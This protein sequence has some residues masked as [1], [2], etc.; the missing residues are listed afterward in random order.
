MIDANQAGVLVDMMIKAG[1][2]HGAV[3]LGSERTY[4]CIP[5]QTTHSE[6]S[7]EEM[8]RIGITPGLV[9]ISCGIEPD[10]IEKFEKVLKE[11]SK[12]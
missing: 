4:Y 12:L 1:V 7:A 3:S 8:A 5:S 9:R 10:L 11:F 6:M 2:G